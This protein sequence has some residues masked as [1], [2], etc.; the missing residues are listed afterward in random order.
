M[1]PQVLATIIYEYDNN[2]NQTKMIITRTDGGKNITQFTYD[3]ENR[4]NKII[5]PDTTTSEYRYDGGGR[6]IQSVETGTITKYLYDGL[7]VIIERD[8]Q[9]TTLA[10]YTRGVGY[11]GDWEHHQR[12]ASEA[13]R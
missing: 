13:G 5:Y 12:G 7:N 3:Y 9:N 8:W 6:R 10:R 4:L 11:G 1:P 2:D